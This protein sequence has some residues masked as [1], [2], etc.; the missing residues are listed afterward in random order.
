MQEIRRRLPPPFGQESALTF[1]FVDPFSMKNL[2]FQ[3]IEELCEQPRRAIDF[4]VLIPTGYDATRNEWLYESEKSD[5]VDRFLG[6]ATW[7]QGWDPA[8]ARGTDFARFVTDS[9]GAAMERLGYIYSGFGETQVIRLPVKNVPL[10]RLALFSRHRLG[11]K[12]WREVRKYAPDQ[13]SLF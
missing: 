11:A 6:D 3:T 12:F 9:F 10:Y 8:R 1:C 13:R 5:V 7:R 2:H 4:L